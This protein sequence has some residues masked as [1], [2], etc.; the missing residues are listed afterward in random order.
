MAI[1]HLHVKNIS[2]GAGRS[3][4]AAAAY[5]AGQTLPNELEERESSFGG[6]RDVLYSEIRLPEGAPD[7]MADRAAL[8]NAVEKA[9]IRKDARLAK[10]IEVAL[11]RELP[12]REWL[13]LVREFADAYVL[14][15]FVVDFAIHDD[16]TLH[17]PHA[18]LLL[19][20]RMIKGNGF[21]PK[22]RAADGKVFVLEAR[23]LWAAVT[24]TTFAK[25]GSSLA[26]NHR[27]HEESGIEREPGRHRGPDR[28]ERRARR[29]VML[30]IDKRVLEA[31]LF[32]EP[33]LPEARSRTTIAVDGVEREV[34][35]DMSGVWGQPNWLIEEVPVPG[36]RGEILSQEQLDR[37]QEV[38]IA[39]MEQE[40]RE[41]ESQP[42]F[43]GRGG[44]GRAHPQAAERNWF[45]RSRG[46]PSR[47]DTIETV[48]DLRQ[49]R[50]PE[51]E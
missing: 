50:Q 17:N 48:E 8:W 46:E 44:E 36:P 30:E 12:R 15:G 39:D 34:D 26:I 28:A 2:R 31:E 24:N 43:R 13:A 32:G 1:F 38:M 10:E 29:S 37:A 7:W 5:R 6:R 49:K 27:S 21:G 51:R 16:G 14:Q 3:V 45:S 18:H 9:E 11:P 23:K 19:T 33:P 40:I 4:V 41:D 35:R 22:V 20:T 47:R 42:W 25:G